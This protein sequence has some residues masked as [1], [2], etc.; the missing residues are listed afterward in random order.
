M[1]GKVKREAQLIFMCLQRKL[2]KGGK[3]D[4]A[5]NGSLRGKKSS[6]TRQSEQRDF[7]IG[8]ND[9]IFTFDT[10]GE[11]KNQKRKVMSTLGAGKLHLGCVFG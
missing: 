1:R 10:G 7:A 5:E 6:E 4:E 8:F 2:N 3:K 9:F 11:E